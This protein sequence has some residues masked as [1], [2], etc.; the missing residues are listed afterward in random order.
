MRDC[1]GGVKDDSRPR[2]RRNY[3]SKPEE[4]KKTASR[5][6]RLAVLRRKT[7]DDL[8]RMLIK[9]AKC[10][11][12]TKSPL[13]TMRP[14][15]NYLIFNYIFFTALVQR[16]FAVKTNDDQRFKFMNAA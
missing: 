2:L 14:D 8:L 12:K 16:A 3:L 7:D 10:M 15:Y 5:G 11:P 4:S 13:K 1:A 9:K 6:W